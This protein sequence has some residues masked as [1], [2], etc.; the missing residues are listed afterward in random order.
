MVKAM[1]IGI[2]AR[3]LSVGKYTGIPF[4]EYMILKE[5]MVKH[6]EHEYYL[7]SLRPICW[8][9]DELPENWHI[10]NEPGLVKCERFK[11]PWWFVFKLPREI[12]KLGLDAYWGPNFSMPRKVKGVEYYVTIHDLGVY[13]FE[14]I[15]QKR[16][17]IQIKLYLPRNIRNARKVLTVSEFTKQDVVRTF[18]TAPDKIV[19]VYNG[20][21]VEWIQGEQDTTAIREEIRGLKEFFLFIGTIE[22]RKNIPTIIK[23]YEIYIDKYFDNISEGSRIP[24][25]VLA[26]GKGWNCEEIYQMVEQS[27]YK[28]YI[29]LTGYISAA[30]KSFLLKKAKCFLYPSLY[31]GFGI[32]V[33]E[34][35]D[36]NTPVITANNSSLPEVG[37]DAALYI[38]TADVD[39]LSEQM[40]KVMNMNEKDR[41]S[42][43]KRMNRQL[44]KFSWEKCAEETMREI[45]E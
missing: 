26:G 21:T 2:D 14:H 3:P 19:T 18:G 33:L 8:R 35:F 13:H 17:E 42:L 40:Y 41:E 16:N 24:K 7:F 29:I 5:W 9:E 34:A 37:G 6:P 36:A 44:G 31:E 12:R 38:E 23:G 32:P 15:G 11:S 30:E 20:G 25:L 4:Y 45:L 43:S 39:G 28:E 10:V 27:E 22:P 1:K